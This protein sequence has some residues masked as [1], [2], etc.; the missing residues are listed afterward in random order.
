MQS[1]FRRPAL[2]G[3]AAFVLTVGVARILSYFW[4]RLLH[5]HLSSGAHLHH[6]VF[7]IFILTAAG[8]LALVFKGPRATSGIALLY[9]LGVGL[10]YDEFGFWVNPPF[11]RG[12]R[13]NSN[14]LLIVGVAFLLVTLVRTAARRRRAAS[15]ASAPSID[16]TT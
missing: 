11:V 3:A 7:G 13:W 10:T 5:V 2:V 9:G 8:Y 15:G 14:G 12:V 16:T 4:P 1:I 6:Y